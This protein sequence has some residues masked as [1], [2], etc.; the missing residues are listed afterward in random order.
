MNFLRATRA[1]T[2]VSSMRCALLPAGTRASTAAVIQSSSSVSAR[3]FTSQA[4]AYRPAWAAQ[5]A[6]ANGRFVRSFCSEKSTDA[7]SS[8]DSGTTTSSPYGS[9]RIIEDYKHPDLSGD[10]RGKRGALELD[11]Y[12]PEHKLAFEYNGYHHYHELPF[13]G[14]IEVYKRRDKE[15]AELCEKYGIRLIVIPY[16]WDNKIES[17]AA[18]IHSHF[19]S[20]LPELAEKAADDTARE[21]IKGLLQKIETGEA[22]A[23]SNDPP[24]PVRVTKGRKSRSKVLGNG[25]QLANAW[26][27]GKDPSGFLISEKLDGVR[28]F[29]SG[30][31][32]VL[33]TRHGRKI[34]SPAWWI[35]QLPKGVDLDGELWMGYAS[36]GKLVG[37]AF[38]KP[39]RAAGETLDMEKAAE[40]LDAGWKEVKFFASDI[41]DVSLPFEKRL[42]KLQG[43]EENDVFKVV[44]YTP[45]EGEEHLQKELD[46]VVERGGE[47]VVLRDP[48]AM[49][50]YGKSDSMFAVKKIFNA[51]VLMVEKSPTTRG[52][53]AQVPSGA[54]QMVRCSLHE[55]TDSVPAKGTVLSIAHFGQWKN[56]GR[57]KFPYLTGSR[58]DLAW[59]EVL[60]K[61]S[62]DKAKQAS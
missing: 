25:L 50:K 14:P 41:P 6:E 58:G 28:V 15:K 54:K 18:T 42:E 22:V 53:I 44:K 20:L 59:E 12:L 11:V 7:E 34:K 5:K 49:Y 16:W 26:D 61:Y 36:L 57:Y 31:D 47:S 48:K 2:P 32:A 39:A 52:L 30:D 33:A 43:L 46:T 60:E 37:S 1:A 62:A 29:L 8:T 10:S 35:E 38:L 23:I 21:R 19:P 56:S 45:C 55:Y 9:A 13:F 51:E 4:R 27:D 17:L 3:A 40:A 24:P